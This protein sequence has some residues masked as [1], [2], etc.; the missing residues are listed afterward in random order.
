MG[1]AGDSEDKAGRKFN[2]ALQL[3]SMADRETD[4]EERERLLGQAREL[5]DQA[6]RENRTG[7]RNGN[8]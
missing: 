1:A 5:K 3:E 4:P 6:K 8:S 7:K 2:K